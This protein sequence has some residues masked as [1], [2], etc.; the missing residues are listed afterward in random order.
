MKLKGA[1]HLKMKEWVLLLTPCGKSPRQS[2]KGKQGAHRP[3]DP[4]AHRLVWEWR[5]ARPKARIRFQVCDTPATASSLS[6]NLPQVRG[7]GNRYS[8]TRHCLLQRHILGRW[9]MDGCSLLCFQWY[10]R[11]G[12]LPLLHTPGQKPAIT[13]VVRS[14]AHGSERRTAREKSHR[15]LA[16]LDLASVTMSMA[17]LLLLPPARRRQPPAQ[18]GPRPGMWHA[19]D[20]QA[21]NRG[22]A[23][24]NPP[25]GFAAGWSR[26]QDAV[27]MPLAELHFLAS[28]H[29]AVSEGGERFGSIRSERELTRYR[30]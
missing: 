28:A 6:H 16:S 30:L 26:L 22:A 18:T 14:P 19:P 8:L 20:H 9:T 7:F 17:V 11:L 29:P 3:T 27:L 24:P 4:Q 10:E 15:R 2:K 25:V 21:R 5:S 23:S 13:G 1:P 12:S